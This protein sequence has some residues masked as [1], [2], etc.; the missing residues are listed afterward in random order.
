MSEP[1]APDWIVWPSVQPDL[2][3]GRQGGG[4]ETIR[5]AAAVHSIAAL[6]TE[7]S[8]WTRDVESEILPLLD[9]LQ[10]ISKQCGFTPAQVALAWLLSRG[11]DTVPIP[12]TKRRGYLE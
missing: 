4:P 11:D 7:Y 8:L 2:K 1:C 6:Q 10:G 12:G 3:L 9:L 5:R